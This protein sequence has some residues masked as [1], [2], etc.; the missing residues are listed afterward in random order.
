MGH[1]LARYETYLPKLNSVR[2][3]PQNATVVVTLVVNTSFLYLKKTMV[4]NSFLRT[5]G[6][7]TFLNRHRQWMLQWP[8]L[9]NN[10]VCSFA[11]FDL[12][13]LSHAMSLLDT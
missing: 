4:V 7:S 5:L 1:L 12:K 8:Y 3:H 9:A 13:T 10:R 2:L 6:L 11:V